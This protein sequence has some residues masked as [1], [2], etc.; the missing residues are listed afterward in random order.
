[1]VTSGRIINDS[2]ILARE[3]SW[4]M[5]TRHRQCNSSYTLK[6]I[7]LPLNF[8]ASGHLKA[9]FVESNTA[10]ENNHDHVAQVDQ[11]IMRRSCKILNDLQCRKGWIGLPCSLLVCERKHGQAVYVYG[12][13]PFGDEQPRPSDLTCGVPQR[14]EAVLQVGC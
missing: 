2:Q 13:C 7:L 8:V 11:Q 10:K 5:A 3:K 1:M 4:Q 6:S 9:C 12:P 14:T